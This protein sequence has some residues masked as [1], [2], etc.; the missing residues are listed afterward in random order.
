MIVRDIIAAV[1]PVGMYFA[2]VYPTIKFKKQLNID[3]IKINFIALGLIFKDFFINTFST[4]RHKIP[5]K[6]NLYP[7]EVYIG[8]CDI[9]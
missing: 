3:D 5:A 7:I 2:D 1:I 8:T 4:I 6:M 9:A